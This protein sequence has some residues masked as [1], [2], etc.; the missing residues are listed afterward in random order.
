MTSTNNLEK[1]CQEKEDQLIEKYFGGIAH[2]AAYEQPETI[3]A[4]YSRDLPLQVEEEYYEF[5]KGLYTKLVG[6][7]ADKSFEQILDKRHMNMFSTREVRYLLDRAYDDA[8]RITLWERLTKTNHE[9][10]NKYKQLLREY[11]LELLD[12]LR[13]DFL[14][15][16]A[17]RR[18]PYNQAIRK[19]ENE[20]VEVPEVGC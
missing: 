13:F 8:K 10:V 1:I 6:I 7:S 4:N 9:D 2:E 15:D 19:F 18:I 11:T 16:I 14:E 3:A 12:C 5:L 20:S 17:T